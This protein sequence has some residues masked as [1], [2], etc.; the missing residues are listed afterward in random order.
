MTKNVLVTAAG[1]TIMSALLWH[2]TARANPPH[3]GSEQVQVYAD[4]IDYFGRTG[5]KLL[6]N[7]TFPLNLSIVAKDAVCLQ[8]IH[9]EAKGK[10]GE[11]VHSL[12]P[13]VL[14]DHP[15]RIIGE[16]DE[17][18]AL[19]QRD[20]SGATGRTDSGGD[21]SDI[22]SDPGILALSEI[23]FDTTHQFAVLKYTFLCGVH[24]NSGG[25]LVLQK[26]GDRWSAKRRPCNGSV[27]INSADPRS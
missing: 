25:I 9:L 16:Q 8:G 19:K 20:K 13:E 11:I 22:P 10:S 6:S 23:I 18:A 12:G 27:F 4:F 14:R 15:I 24:C 17:L 26:V 21:S 2:A 5:F 7:K 3:L 1:M